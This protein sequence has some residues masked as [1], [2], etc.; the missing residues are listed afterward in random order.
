[1]KDINKIIILTSFTGLLTISLFG[2]TLLNKDKFMH[3]GQE[4]E[5]L[6][7]CGTVALDNDWAVENDP[8]ASYGE[9]LFKAN[10]KACHRMDRNLVGPALRNIYDYRDSLWITK[11]IVNGNQLVKRKDKIAVDLYKE[12]NN[13]S[14]TEFTSFKN[15]DV[16][17]LM[18]YLKATQGPVD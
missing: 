4:Q 17:A 16:D 12:Y 5:E 3:G 18:H 11:M 14:H 2:F 6:L 1:M 15:E 8:K 7:Y 9:M 13:A 10:C